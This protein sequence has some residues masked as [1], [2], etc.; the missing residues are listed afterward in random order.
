MEQL[1]QQILKEN[2]RLDYGMAEMIAWF[3]ETP[4]RQKQLEEIINKDHKIIKSN[5]E[6]EIK[7]IT[8]IN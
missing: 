6:P 1:I 5:H 4:E 7:S 8:I 2:P 3:N